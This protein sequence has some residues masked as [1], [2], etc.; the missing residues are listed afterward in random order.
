MF[1]LD[2]SVQPFHS[3]SVFTEGVMVE[4]ASIDMLLLGGSLQQSVVVKQC[5]ILLTNMAVL[6]DQIIWKN[7]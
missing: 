5:Y 1:F 3:D 7:T 4:I 6:R 2:I